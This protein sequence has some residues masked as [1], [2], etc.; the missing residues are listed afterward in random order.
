MIVCLAYHIMFISFFFAKKYIK[1]GAKKQMEK[2]KISMKG[3]KYPQD[4][5]EKLMT[6]SLN[7]DIMSSMVL[8]NKKVAEEIINIVQNAI[9]KGQ[10]KKAKVH[11]ELIRVQHSIRNWNG[12]RSIVID[13][14]AYCPEENKIYII[15]PQC[16]W[17]KNIYCRNR[18]YGSMVDADSLQVGQDFSEMPKRCMIVL[19]EKDF[20]SKDPMIQHI[21][22]VDL[23][24][25]NTVESGEEEIIV[26]LVAETD[27][28][29]L[30]QF[31]RDW[32]N[33]NPDD[34]KNPVFAEALRYYKFNPKGVDKM[35][36]MLEEARRESDIKYISGLLNYGLS[37]EK[38]AKDFELDEAYVKEIKSEIDSKKESS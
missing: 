37:V 19:T 8:K 29:E 24:S 7:A 20:N 31:I 3:G 16:Y 2:E 23:M 14:I 36:S 9:N 6:L 15:E 30:G 32:T 34:I 38:I 11:L 12:G 17:Q 33:P 5:Q 25:G 4:F 13:F 28:S 26:N 22:K 27:N 35:Y 18:Y 1:R 10:K 21:K